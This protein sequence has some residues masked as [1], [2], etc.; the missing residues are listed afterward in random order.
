MNVYL[1]L[2][3][4][5]FITVFCGTDKFHLTLKAVENCIYL[6][7]ARDIQHSTLYALYTSIHN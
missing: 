5:N 1:L 6:Y 7:D 2:L 3:Q 4:L